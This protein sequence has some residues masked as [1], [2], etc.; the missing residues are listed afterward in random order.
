VPTDPLL[1]PFRLKHLTL[2]NRIVST[3]HE[4]AYSEDGLPKDR[5][6]A[7]HV[8][9]ARGGVG[10]TMIGG[11]AIVS[12][13][14]AP[15][16][17]NLQV[18]KDEC[19]PWLRRLADEVHAHGA[20][21]M[22][23]L[24]HLG[25]RT[26]STTHEWLPAVSASATREPAHRAFAKAAE[27][28]DLDRIRDDFVRAAQA[29]QA[30]GLDGV[31]LMLYGHFL[32]S[33]WTPF[34]NHR[35]DEYGGSY[36][37]RMRYP[38]EVI[39]AVRAAVT[40]DFLVGARMSFDEE[41]TP[42]VGL[43][44]ALRMGRDITAAGIDFVSVVK[45]SIESDRALARMIPPMGTPAAPHLELAGRVR[46][47]LT[48]PVM[49][50]ARI[51][52][53]AT[54]RYAVEAGLLDLVG[55]TRALLADPYL[56]LKTATGREDEIRP[57]VGANMCI[58]SIYT[59]GA[60]YCIHNPSSGR[61]LELP[62]LV[63]PAP[64]RRRVAVVGGGPA[65]LEA[66]RVLGERGHAVTLFEAN[67]RLGGQLALAC[68]SPRR[69]DLQGVVDWRA[70]ELRRLAVEV[71]LGTYA[72][73]D[74]LADGGYDVVVVATGGMPVPPDIP[75]AQ[76]VADGW[77]VVSGARHLTGRVLV[78][79]DHGG[80]QALDVTEALLRGGAEVELV[81][82]ERT[83]SPDVGG[84]VG[85]GYFTALADGGVRLTS[86]RRLLSV[87]RSADGLV[88]LLGAEGASRTE[89][90]LVDAVVVE[91]GTEPVT[92]VYDALLPG[93][94]NQGAVDL[95]ALLALRPQTAVRNPHGTYQLFRIGDAVAS[96]NVHAAMLDAARIA[97]AI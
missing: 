58:D 62:H 22:I 9:K 23:Q 82:P 4:P 28:W 87:E 11:S 19:V 35:D 42:G 56:P 46:R 36:A 92:D 21:V 33:F 7:Y 13:D 72:E 29:C 78:Y 24:T 30:A 66:A 37:N 25:H 40:D 53:V 71:R 3:S 75:G 49:H 12:R 77:D 64:A 51:A 47:E 74:L 27:P 93:S 15:A 96:R 5:Y 26:S 81:T 50:A 18:W 10:L 20:A 88:A 97:R 38:L 60:A 86:L 41:R 94:T 48:V 59:S 45:G 76:L 55:M 65:G 52:D 14:S 39:R 91:A 83:V 70:Q 61:E 89:S 69:R 17:G 63:S 79:D 57:C 80:N 43:D 1:T 44:E 31:E 32:D 54:A 68:L 34:W 73:G 6:R 90:R 67:S 16:F 95:D 85:A 2:R 84:L 8:E